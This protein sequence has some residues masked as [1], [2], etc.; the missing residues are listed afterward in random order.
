MSDGEGQQPG[1]TPQGRT[2]D[3]AEAREELERPAHTPQGRTDE[4]AEEDETL[5]EG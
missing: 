1:G 3:E 4:E 2:D 5:G